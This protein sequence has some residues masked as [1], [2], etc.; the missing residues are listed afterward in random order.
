MHGK[1]GEWR[2]EAADA[3]WDTDVDEPGDDVFCWWEAWDHPTCG[4]PAIPSTVP[5]CEDEDPQLLHLPL[6]VGAACSSVCCKVTIKGL[7]LGV[8]CF[9]PEGVAP[10]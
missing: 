3:D 2:S 1:D 6:P 7:N 5:T 4:A 9:Q 10:V 8:A